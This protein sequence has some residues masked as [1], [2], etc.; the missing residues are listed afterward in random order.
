MFSKLRVPFFV[1]QPP[2]P[3]GITLLSLCHLVGIG[4]QGIGGNVDTVAGVVSNALSFALTR[5]SHVLF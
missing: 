5:E 4:A 3:T 1:T 2:V